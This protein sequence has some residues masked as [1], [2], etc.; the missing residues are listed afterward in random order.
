MQVTVQTKH[1]LALLHIAA[2]NDIR[3]YLNAVH[4]E[5]HERETILVGRAGHAMG[6]IRSAPGVEEGPTLFT[7][8][9]PRATVETFR[10]AGPMLQ[11]SSPDGKQWTLRDT[12]M[13][14]SATWM[15]DGLRFP[16]WRRVVPRNTSGAAAQ[17]NPDNLVVMHKVAAALG[18]KTQD[19][20]GA[21]F[22]IAHNGA[23]GAL[24]QIRDVPEFVGVLMPYREK[25]VEGVLRK[26]AP[27]WVSGV[28]PAVEANALA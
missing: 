12:L 16:D 5:A 2:K 21:A 24:V 7:V 8:Q 28:A 17:F 19:K 9:I 10:K 15:A 18:I 1:L 23:D 27:G 3:T 26:S 22:L 4:V 20:R 14:T 6:V 11:L 25:A 13:G